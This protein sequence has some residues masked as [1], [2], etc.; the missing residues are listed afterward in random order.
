MLKSLFKI[1]L[2]DKSSADMKEI[3]P[4]VDAVHAA[5]QS[6]ESLSPDGLRGEISRTKRAHK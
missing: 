1:F 3:Q 5:E 4:T 6:L 2:G